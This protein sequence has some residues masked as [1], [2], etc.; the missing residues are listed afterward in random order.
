MCGIAIYDNFEECIYSDYVVKIPEYYNNLKGYHAV[1][2]IGYDE[3]KFQ[4]L[5]SYGAFFGECGC[6]YLSNEFIMNNELAF[7]FWCI[8]LSNI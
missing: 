7:D 6:F 8:E 2:I 5:N 3:H 1:L 4:I